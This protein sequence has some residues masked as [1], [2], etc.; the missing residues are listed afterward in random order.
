MIVLFSLNWSVRMRWIIFL[1]TWFVYAI[2]LLTVLWQHEDCIIKESAARVLQLIIA[3]A[4]GLYIM[5]KK[6]QIHQNTIFC[7]HEQ[8]KDTSSVDKLT[9]E[10]HF[11]LQPAVSQVVNYYCGNLKRVHHV[12]LSGS[13]DNVYF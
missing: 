11:V 6:S 1:E 12:S 13:C 2:R 10:T 9:Q 5:I 3:V 4:I 8:C 7:Y